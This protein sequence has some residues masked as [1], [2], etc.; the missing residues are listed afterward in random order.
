MP[1]ETGFP[2]PRQRKFQSN[3]RPDLTLDFSGTSENPFPTRNPVD[4]RG[5]GFKFRLSRRKRTGF[6]GLRR[7]EDTRLSRQYQR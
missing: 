5:T 7:L 1:G 2:A 3:E 6:V 4:C